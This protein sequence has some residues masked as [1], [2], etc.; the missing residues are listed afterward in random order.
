MMATIYYCQEEGCSVSMT[1]RDGEM[2]MSAVE[3]HHNQVMKAVQ[4]DQKIVDSAQHLHRLYSIAHGDITSEHV[5]REVAAVW[6]ELGRARQEFFFRLARAEREE[7]YKQPECPPIQIELQ[8]IR[9][10]VQLAKQQN[11]AQ[12]YI[13]IDEQG[14]LSGGWF[15]ADF[16]L[17]PNLMMLLDVQEQTEEAVI[18]TLRMLLRNREGYVVVDRVDWSK[19]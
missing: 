4:V 14:K 17:Q 5:M 19:K 11:I 1:F 6:D 18:Y 10:L 2:T 16:V 15:R 9:H 13:I 7:A 12:F 8:D 3:V